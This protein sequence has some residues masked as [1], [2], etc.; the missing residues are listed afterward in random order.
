M[1]QQLFK[2]YEHPCNI[3]AKFSDDGKHRLVLWRSW[4]VTRPMAMCIGL[5]PST[6]N[7]VSNDP[8]ITRLVHKSGLLHSNGFGGLYMLNLYTQVTP[9]PKQ[10][11]LTTICPAEL[12]REYTDKTEAVIFCWGSFK[13]AVEPSRLLIEKGLFTEPKCF[14]KNADGSPKHP[15]YLPSKTKLINY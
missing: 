2:F 12:I 4:D 11:D 6:A 3:G 10:L 15:L 5:N 13:Q 1:D 9:F 14:G 7:S 8:T